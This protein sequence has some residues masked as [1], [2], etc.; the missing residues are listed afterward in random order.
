MKT[1]A[2]QHNPTHSVRLLLESG[3]QKSKPVGQDAKNS[4]YY[5]PS[6]GEYAVEGYLVIHHGPRAG[7]SMFIMCNVYLQLHQIMKKHQCSRTITHLATL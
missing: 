4:F 7:Q 3:E 2:G 6:P 1:D 5:A